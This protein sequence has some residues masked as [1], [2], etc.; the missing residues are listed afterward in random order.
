MP[1]FNYP[2]LYWLVSRWNDLTPQGIHVDSNQQFSLITS[3]YRKLLSYQVNPP[4]CPHITNGMNCSHSLQ[5]VE[6]LQYWNHAW[7]HDNACLIRWRLCQTTTWR[8][9]AQ[10]SFFPKDKEFFIPGSMSSTNL[11]E[12]RKHN[13]TKK[14]LQ[15]N[16]TGNHDFTSIEKCRSKPHRETEILEKILKRRQSCYFASI[17]PPPQPP[18]DLLLWLKFQIL[19]S[20]QI[21]S[22]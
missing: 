16:E 13:L 21:H 18:P 3:P 11:K 7:H 19:C 12:I 20:L 1:A 14:Y 5:P 22:N 4:S 6:R 15:G 2:Y 17:L 8:Q 9:P 10:D